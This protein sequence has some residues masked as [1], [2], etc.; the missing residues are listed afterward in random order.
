MGA[1]S[2]VI[3][4][5][6]GQYHTALQ[7]EVLAEQIETKAYERRLVGLEYLLSSL[8]RAKEQ[9][10]ALQ[11]DLDHLVADMARLHQAPAEKTY[12]EA[13]QKSLYESRQIFQN[14]AT[15]ADESASHIAPDAQE[16]KKNRMGGEFALKA[17][18][19]T[20]AVRQLHALNSQVAASALSTITVLFLAAAG[21]LATI[22]AVCFWIIW[23][24][25]VGLE[26]RQAEQ[27]A[28]LGSIGDG[29]FAIDPAGR[30]ILF[31]RAAE[32]I[33]GFSR[34]EAMFQP[35]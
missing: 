23:R 25:A 1:I 32:T 6:F 20:D 9:W 24:N 28:I 15:T 8:D 13:V 35:Y 7:K 12:I 31:N 33:S 34:A 11:D 3:F 14:F 29:V 17:Q 2:G 16:S 27:A 22:L 26:R 19:T 10:L 5:S 21:L 4:R 30:I 18:Q